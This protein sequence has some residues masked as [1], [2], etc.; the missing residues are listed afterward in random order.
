[1]NEENSKPE[2]NKDSLMTCVYKALSITEKT[3]FEMGGWFKYDIHISSERYM[4]SERDKEIVDAP[5]VSLKVIFSPRRL[6]EYM[7]QPRQQGGCNEQA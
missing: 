7:D 4:E 6:R 3:L 2:V 5:A 1:M